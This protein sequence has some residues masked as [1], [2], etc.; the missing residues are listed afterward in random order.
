MA[1]DPKVLM[2]RAKRTSQLAESITSSSSSSSS[3]S[4][5]SLG[6]R[7]GLGRDKN[8]QAFWVGFSA[9]A[10]PSRTIRIALALQT[11]PLNNPNG[12]SEREAN[13]SVSQQQQQQQQQDSNSSRDAKIQALEQR[14]WQAQQCHSPDDVLRVLLLDEVRILILI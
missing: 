3:S 9:P 6:I 8:D 4:S 14:A 11:P 5:G 10:P 13:I 2:A 12:V 7:Q 1:L